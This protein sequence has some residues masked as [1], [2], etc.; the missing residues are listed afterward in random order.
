VRKRR[1]ILLLG[2]AVLVLLAGGI[3]A[4][5]LWPQPPCD[6]ERM[7]A[8]IRVGMTPEEVYDEQLHFNRSPEFGPLPR[9]VFVIEDFGTKEK[10]AIPQTD[11]SAVFITWD[12]NGDDL[13]VAAV[14]ARLPRPVPA[15]TRLRR[16]IARALPFI[17]E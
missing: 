17:G 8:L 5:L 2:L 10:E 12:E 16:T 15:L 11:G 1:R 6:A 7:A 14:R 3:G 4:A 9:P 13:R